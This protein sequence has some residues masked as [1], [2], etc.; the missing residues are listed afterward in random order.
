MTSYV[1]LEQCSVS[2]SLLPTTEEILFC[3]LNPSPLN[4][5]FFLSDQLKQA[6]WQH[7]TL[8]LLVILDGSLPGFKQFP[9]M[10]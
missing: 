2:S 3:V 6:L 9:P 5:E 8:L 7:W 10:H 4:R 1:G